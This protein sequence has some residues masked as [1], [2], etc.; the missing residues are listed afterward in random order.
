MRKHARQPIP[1]DPTD[2]EGL[3]ALLS[4]YL[5][6]MQ[7]HHYA[8]ATATI[9]RVTLSKFILWCDDRSVTRA[10]DV[11]RDMIERY[12]R[13]L[14]YYRKRDGQPLCLSS[15]S[16]RLIGLRSWFAWMVRQRL[17]EHSPA[18]D[19]ILPR[20]EKR[21]PRHA[22]TREE[23][24]RV[25]A[26]PDVQN[27]F[28]L[29][30]R[31]I[32]ETLYSTGL[33]RAEVISLHVTDLDAQRGVVL[34]RNGKGHKD[35]YVPIGQRAVAWI[36]KDQRE[37][38]DKLMANDRTTRLL[39][40]TD[41][42][43]KIH[44]NQLSLEVRR[45]FDEAGITKPGACHIF[46]HTAATLMLESGADI[47]FIQALLGHECLSTTQIYT[48][49]SISKLCEV[50]RQTHPARLYRTDDASNGDRSGQ[51]DPSAGSVPPVGGLLP[52]VQ[53]ASDDDPNDD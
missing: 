52:D 12:Q 13:H 51:E 10:A 5:I 47:R 41:M 38:R 28:G 2:P 4:R 14:F 7:T 36:D 17:L 40:V 43:R 16:H 50:H 30:L 31:A 8:E 11:T 46:R 9:R 39:F 6:W 20:E 49:V 42:S 34:V 48:H 27:P 23:V 32:L 24:E 35:R 21:L 53:D 45:L 18:A 3:T 19:M 44:P 37:A 29:R 22:L 15:Q 25:L 33:R 1:G 26:L